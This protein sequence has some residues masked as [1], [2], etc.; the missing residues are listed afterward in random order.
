MN[1]YSR[2]FTAL[3]LIT[4]LLIPAVQAEPTGSF[5]ILKMSPDARSAALGETGVAGAT[6]AVTAFHNPALTAFQPQAQ[7]SFTYADWL[8]DLN[9]LSGALL[10]NYKRMAIGLSFNVFNVPDLERRILPADNP[11]DN[12]DAHDMV[13][14]LSLGYRL[15]DRLAVGV[16]GKF[17]F[18][19]IYNYEAMGGAVDAGAAYRFDFNHLIV[20]VALRNFGQMQ[21][22][23]NERSDLPAQALAG[24]SAQ[25]IGNGEFGLNGLADVRM[26]LDDDTRL[27]GG[28][29][30]FWKENLFLRVGYQ[31]GSELR[32]FS[33]GLGLHW[34]NYAFDYA[35]QP[36][37]E[38]FEATHRFTLNLNF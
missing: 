17:L 36:I 18:Q 4:C 22:L 20:A 21:E 15:T 29:E 2:L 13:T 32:T 7:A 14:G 5:P 6:G 3:M 35:Y 1:K 24:A 28:L 25:I 19:Q 10:F 11:I 8:L 31:T 12:F 30:G 27:H 37:A 9:V 33:G 16:T 23:D 38:D 34:K 26:Y